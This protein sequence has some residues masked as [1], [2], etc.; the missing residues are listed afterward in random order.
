MQT[1]SSIYLDNAATTQPSQGVCE[2]VCAVMREQYGNPSSLHGKGLEAERIVREA[3]A[4]VSAA[5]GADPGSVFFTS[6][7]T[8]ANNMA[9]AGVCARG[10]RGGANRIVT[11]AA[12][13]MS[14]L[15][16][17]RA[18]ESKGWE[19]A[20]LPA[21][22]GGGSG[23]GSGASNGG[24]YGSG[25]GNSGGGRSSSGAVSPD[26]LEAALDG[27]VALI[28]LA[29]V[30]NETGAVL[31]LDD[32]ISLR[33]RVCPGALLHLDCAQS[34]MKLPQQPGRPGADIIC[35]SAHKIHGPKG[36]G[37]IC[38]SD[39]AR[40]SPLVLGG[41]QEGGMRSGTENTP[42]IAGFGVAAQEAA[43][44]LPESAEHAE[45]LK[46]AMLSVLAASGIEYDV[47][48]GDGYCSPYILAIAL[49]GVPA[50]LM[51]NHMDREG[52]YISSGAACSSR[53]ASKTGSHV[54]AAMGLKPE[55]AKSAIRISFSRFNTIAE[56]ETA[57]EK[58]IGAAP[59]IKA[60]RGAT[61]G[62]GAT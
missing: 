13:H 50:E 35:V 44:A 48:A 38:V 22:G 41:G 11:S 24:G 34:F 16:P 61:A 56:V 21:G 15:A 30:N 45:K 46:R 40:L 29:H 20:Y 10:P 33:D 31:H 6:G 59:R 8:E 7:G 17:I 49:P 32:V 58:L 19:V 5:L 51:L 14:I 60:A 43:A 53:R 37:A 12:E 52:V 2:A 18:M 27:R 57:A 55:L 9:V 28:S 36:V 25:A 4:R 3:R 47:I 23:G 26:V 39:R 54:L 1:D 62:R 42:A